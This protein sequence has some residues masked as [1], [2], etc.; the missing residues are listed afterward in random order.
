LKAYHKTHPERLSKNGN[1]L[2]KIIGDVFIH[3][4]AHVDETAV[5]G[6][7]VSISAGVT[8]GAGCRVLESII[9]RN[10]VIQNHSLIMYSIIGWNSFI[11]AWARVEGTPTDPDPNKPYAKIE[12]KSLFTNKG[13]LNP[14]IT[15]IG[16]SV[17]V[18]HEMLI[19]NSIILPNKEIGHSYN[20]EIIL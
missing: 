9:L 11:G 19:R 7:N 17:I 1:N 3:P 6:P 15:I 18:P 5:L 14:S 8:I 12:H 20:N 10:T 4:S 16:S 13:K 2:P